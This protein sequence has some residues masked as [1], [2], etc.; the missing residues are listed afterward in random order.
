[1]YFSTFL[2]ELS[3]GCSKIG[4]GKRSGNARKLREKWF[5]SHQVYNIRTTLQKFRDKYLT[6]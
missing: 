1:M 6:P 5:R 2:N 3:S 4:K